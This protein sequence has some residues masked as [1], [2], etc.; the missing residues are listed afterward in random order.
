M[1]YSFQYSVD[2]T[3]ENSPTYAHQIAYIPYHTANADWSLSRNKTN[4]RV[5][6]S[7]IGGRYS[8]N[9]NVSNNYLDP[10][11]VL[12]ASISHGIEVKYN[13]KINFQFQVKNI[14]GQNYTYIRS[15]VMPG[16][17]F[18]ISLNYEL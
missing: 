7:F 11:I 14:I 13:H 6:S 8:L 3:D 2:V 10:F 16:R 1:N 5:S 15:F 12:D 4:F 17:N 9:E 18:L